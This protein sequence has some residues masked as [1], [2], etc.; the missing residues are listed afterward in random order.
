MA[1]LH[2]LALN[3]E[4]NLEQLATGLASAGAGDQTVQAVSAMAD[5]TRKIAAALGKGQ[6]QTGDG[7]PPAQPE[8]PKSFDQASQQMMADR[9]AANQQ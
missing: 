4:K 9:K 6:E 3:A 8:Q 2:E 7:E 5:A 1:D